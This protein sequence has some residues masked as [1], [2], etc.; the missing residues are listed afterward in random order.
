MSVLEE[1]SVQLRS[2][3]QLM[4]DALKATRGNRTEA[5]KLLGMSRRTLHRKMTK[6]DLY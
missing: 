3:S 4:I 6:Y 2:G 1:S 5:A